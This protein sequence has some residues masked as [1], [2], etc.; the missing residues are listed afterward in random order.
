MYTG[1]QDPKKLSIS[2]AQPPPTCPRKGYEGDFG[3][4]NTPSV[5]LSNITALLPSITKLISNQ[6]DT[7]RYIKERSG[8]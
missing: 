5:R 3:A 8:T 2:R 1:T 6:E 4:H 7:V